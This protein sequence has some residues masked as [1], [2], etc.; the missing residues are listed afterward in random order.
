LLD[1]AQAKG[2]AVLG[3]EL[4]ATEN[5][6]PEG[7]RFHRFKKSDDATAVLLKVAT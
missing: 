1:A 7:A 5:A 2:L 4:R 6:D 3:S